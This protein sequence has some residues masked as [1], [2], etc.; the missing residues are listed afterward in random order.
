MKNFEQS[1]GWEAKTVQPFFDSVHNTPGLL[2]HSCFMATK[3][4]RKQFIRDDGPHGQHLGLLLHGV[5]QD[6]AHSFPMQYEAEISPDRKSWKGKTII[7]K[8]YFPPN[9]NR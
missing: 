8:H 1:S 2:C 5:R 6:I 9:V 4:K 7:P 3:M